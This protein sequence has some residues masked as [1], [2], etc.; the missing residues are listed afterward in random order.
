MDESGSIGSS[1]FELMKEF[2]HDESDSFDIHPDGVRI[3]VLTYSDS[4]TFEFFLNTYSTKEGVFDAIDNII[5]N[6]GGTNTAEALIAIH[7]YAFTVTYGARPLSEGIPRV[8]IVITDGRSNSYSETSDAAQQLHNDGIIVF[9]IGID[10][11]DINELYAIA[12]HPAYVFNISFFNENL[13]GNLQLIVSNEVCTG[14]FLYAHTFT[15]K[16]VKPACCDINKYAVHSF[17]PRKSL[18][19]LFCIPDRY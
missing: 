12:S 2:V 8:T 19:P 1:N 3:G 7:S 9:A 10:G 13:L 17:S 11:A 6:R 18:S 4:Y 15:N 5:Y 14:K 16:V